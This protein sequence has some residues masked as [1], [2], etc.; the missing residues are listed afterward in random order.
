MRARA[1]ASFRVN[2]H[3]GRKRGVEGSIVL[4]SN[5]KMKDNG[6]CLLY[7]LLFSLTSLFLVPLTSFTS[8]S[9][10]WG[11]LNLRVGCYGHSFI[12]RRL[13]FSLNNPLQI[14][15]PLNTPLFLSESAKINLVGFCHLLG[16]KKPCNKSKDSNKMENE[17]NIREKEELK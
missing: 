16:N 6:P 12:S 17:V 10:I 7:A 5:L 14:L 8:A 3:T 9:D 13:S 4:K 2:P 15:F 1:A 11:S